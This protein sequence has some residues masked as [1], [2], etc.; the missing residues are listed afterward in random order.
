MRPGKEWMRR[1]KPPALVV[2]GRYSA[3][4][5]PPGAEAYKRDVPDAE[6]HLLN[7]GARRK[8]DDIAKLMIE[9]PQKHRG[10]SVML[11]GSTI[12]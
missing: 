5:I 1:H 9:F 10:Q 2:W 8:V 4:F 7:A 11:L 6:V 3:S 12:V